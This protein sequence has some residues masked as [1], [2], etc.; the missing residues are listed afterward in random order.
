M[1]Q[2]AVLYGDVVITG[3]LDVQG[4]MSLPSGCVANANVASDAAIAAS[5]CQRGPVVSHSQEG[6]CTTKTVIL[7]VICGAT[8]TLKKVRVSNVTACGGASTVTVDVQNNGVSVLTAVATLNAATGALG[9]ESP[10]IAT[11]AAV[12][13]DVI[14]AVITANASGTDVLATGVGVVLQFDEAY[15]A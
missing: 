6:T 14:T 12:V 3:Q 9:V 4:A 1:A 2:A 5:K 13:D 10:T 11:P 8:A 15:V 7:T